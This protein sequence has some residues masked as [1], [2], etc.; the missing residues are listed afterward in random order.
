[1]RRDIQRSLPPRR[2]EQATLVA[3]ETYDAE[4]SGV[5]PPSTVT[6]PHEYVSVLYSPD[7]NALIRR[8]G[9]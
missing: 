2:R 6:T 3:E 8:A 1:M 4:K 7:G 5:A 9:F